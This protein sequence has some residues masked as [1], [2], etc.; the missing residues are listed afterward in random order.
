[1][2]MS[3]FHCSDTPQ[4]CS[5]G[6]VCEPQAPNPQ[7][8]KFTVVK[9][10]IHNGK[11]ILLVKYEGCTTFDGHK[12]LLLKWKWDHREVLDPHLLGELHMVAARFEPNEKGWELARICASQ[13]WD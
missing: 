4:T 2:G 10:E 9:E 8:N 7:P 12:L 13:I 5:C 11:S 1:M 6:R 3:L